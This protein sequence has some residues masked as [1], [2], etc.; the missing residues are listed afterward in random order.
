MTPF[1]PKFRAWDAC[2]PGGKTAAGKLA[3][4]IDLSNLPETIATLTGNSLLLLL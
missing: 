3:V 1:P 2:W 4:H